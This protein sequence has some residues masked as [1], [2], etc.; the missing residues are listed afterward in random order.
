MF[1]TIEKYFNDVLLA[2]PSQQ[3]T[4]RDEENLQHDVFLA[5]R[6]G[7]GGVYVGGD[8]YFDMIDT[9]LVNA[10]EHEKTKTALILGNAGIF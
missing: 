6:L 4:P 10:D 8:K 1:E 9:F 5:S 2:R 7:M 3:L